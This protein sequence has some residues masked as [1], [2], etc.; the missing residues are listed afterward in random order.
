[1]GSFVRESRSSRVIE[2]LGDLA[3]KHMGIKSDKLVSQSLGYHHD[4]EQVFF[5]V[6]IKT[7]DTAVELMYPDAI[8]EPENADD[9]SIVET[10]CAAFQVD[11]EHEDR[12]EIIRLLQKADV[13][14]E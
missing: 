5:F 12:Q 7:D 14:D 1:M 4:V 10:I 2:A 6:S 3:V 13:I 11:E 8:F 9:E